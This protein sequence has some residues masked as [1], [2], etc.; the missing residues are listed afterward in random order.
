MHPEIVPGHDSHL[1][2]AVTVVTPTVDGI[3]E[4]TRAMDSVRRQHGPV[5]QHVVVADDSAVL[6]DNRTCRALV[7]R[8]PRA[9]V[10][11]HCSEAGA[12]TYLPAR[13]AVVRN[14]GI[15]LATAPL[16]AH[17]DDDNEYEPDHL[18]GLVA[19]LKADP[20]ASIAYSWRRL[21]GPD[22]QEHDPEGRNPWFED[23]D[24]SRRFFEMQR[25]HGIFGAE[26]GVMRDL[27]QAPDGNDLCHLD[28]SELLVPAAVHRRLR[29]RTVFTEEEQADRLCEDRAF[30]ID[31]IR[32]GLRFACS[33]RASLRYHLG[34]YS[35]G[36]GAARW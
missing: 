3:D 17:L 31:A 29:F 13:T 25:R 32:L 28:S 33:R 22:G 2:A 18:Q 36:V 5:V 1:A 20:V 35:N 34:G 30:C 16:V 4:L 27:P 26:G 10:I 21:V 8:F 12:S 9:L 6:A 7:R 24:E 23:E 19:A 14:L 15:E 11:R